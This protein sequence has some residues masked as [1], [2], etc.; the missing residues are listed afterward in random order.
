MKRGVSPFFVLLILGDLLFAGCGYAADPPP[1][2]EY[3]E[4]EDAFDAAAAQA[5][6]PSR[7]EY[8]ELYEASR[9]TAAKKEQDRLAQA[10]L[11]QLMKDAMDA[12]WARDTNRSAGVAAGLASTSYWFAGK[13]K[14][15]GSHR[16]PRNETGK[17]KRRSVAEQNRSGRGCSQLGGHQVE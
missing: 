9:A 3:L 17:S 11:D 12:L 5:N 16:W 1:R 7:N 2:N 15:A 4:A 10:H 14:S 6:R 13:P 8:I